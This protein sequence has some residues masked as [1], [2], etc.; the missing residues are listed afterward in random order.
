M[1]R[2]IDVGA[3]PSVAVN[4]RPIDN[5]GLSEC[6]CIPSRSAVRRVRFDRRGPG[7]AE[8]HGANM[9]QT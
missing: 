4:R 6:P 2:R 3:N 8:E 9:S 7:E 1:K 5:A